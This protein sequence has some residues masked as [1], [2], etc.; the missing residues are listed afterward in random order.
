[1]TTSHDPIYFL[2]ID[3][4]T[5]S[6][7]ALIF[8]QFGSEIAKARVPIEPYFS[9][10]PNYAEQHADYYWQKL[11]EACQKLWQS[12]EIKPEQIAGV[13]LATQRY[14]MI[15]L[16]K[17]KQP[18]RPAIVWMDLRRAETHDIGFL[19]PLTKIIGMGELVKDAQQKARCN[20]LAQNEPEIWAQT[21]HYVNLSAYLTY[22]LV[23]ELI[24]SNGHSVGYLP[25]DYKA[26]TWLKPKD[27][28]WRLF[29]CT[30]EQ[31]P[32]IIPPGQTLGKISAKAAKATGIPKGT[33]MIA[34]ASD[35][36]CE[37]LGAAGLAADTACLSFGTTA[38]INTISSDYVEVLKHMPAYTA[39]A[40]HYYN[41]EY[42]IY[43]GFWMVSWFKE[44]FAHYEQALAKTQGIDAEK[45][46]D[47]AVK[48]IPAGSMGLTMQPYWSPGVR[49]PGLEGKGA[50]IGF[51]DVHTR[52]HVYRAILEGLAYE[53]KLGFDT[54]EKRTSK[55]IKHLRVSGGGSQSDSAMQLTADIFGMPAYRPHTYEAS[56]L[57]AAI[58]CAVG[59]G[60]YPDHAAA[61]EA[62]THLGDEFIPIE[63]NVQLYKRL[64]NEVYL[65]MYERL[66]PLYQSIQDI[67]GYPAK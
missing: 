42:M 49:H 56:G 29:S 34:A 64:Y 8:D 54:I 17:D 44:Q 47:A 1:M 52:A 22:Q 19:N 21:A 35:K 6:V 63:A 15:C 45:L 10:Q 28:K 65:K 46:L 23:G 50:L 13:S 39:A 59:L 61:S 14:T 18:L 27:L 57:G 37:A 41:H 43:R 48:D 38:T 7:R 33:P 66:K 55:T 58:N 62:M 12:C 4:G 31:M 51:G 30:P 40:P 24:D 16:D 5:Q 9:E 26:Q 36:A 11:C 67:T 2:A 60:V 53:L 25:Y 32:K 20:W 3:N